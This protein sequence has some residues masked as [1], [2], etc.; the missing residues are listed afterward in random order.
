M[1]CTKI[2]ELLASYQEFEIVP[3]DIPI[4]SAEEGAAYFQIAVGQTAP[5][6]ILKGDSKFYAAVISGGRRIN[7]EEIAR[8]LGCSKVKLA[9]RKKVKEL[10]GHEAG[11]IPMVGL[12]M[13]Y[14]L[15]KELFKYDYVY[16]GTGETDKTLRIAP[17]VLE[18][19]NQVIAKFA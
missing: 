11:A 12:T 16:G 18:K 8:L 5:T 10:T 17:A 4:R 1:D 13:P 9:D 15:D 14:I 19:V 2:T 6:L 7:M 3:N